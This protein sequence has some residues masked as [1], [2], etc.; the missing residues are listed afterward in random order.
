MRVELVVIDTTQIQR[1]IF[2]SNR[3]R[4]NLGASFL[5]SCAT[6]EWVAE[7]LPYD[8]DVDK[9]EDQP[10]LETGKRSAEIVY[11]GG[12]NAVILFDAD[13]E[14]RTDFMKGYSRLLLRRAPGLEVAW[15]MDTL[16]D[17]NPRAP[18]QLKDKL[19]TVMKKLPNAKQQRARPVSVLGLGITVPCQST[20][21]PAVTMSEIKGVPDAAQYPVS[22]EIYAKLKNGDSATQRLKNFLEK[23]SS[24][25]LDK[26]QLKLPYD[27]DNIGRSRGE[28]SYIAVVHAD[29]DGVGEWLVK[30]VAVDAPNDRAYI[31]QKRDAS[32]KLRVTAQKA[33]Q[34]TVAVLLDRAAREGQPR[35]THNNVAG[36]EITAVHF[37]PE[38]N[39]QNKPTGWHYLPFRPIVFGGDDVTFI[40]DGRLAL[41][42]TTIYLQ[43]FAQQA[44]YYLAEHNANLTA[45]AGVAI[46]KSHYPFA[47][48]Y[49]LAEQLI[50]SAKQYRHDL[51]KNGQQPGACIDWHF[52]LG[53]LLGDLQEIRRQHYCTEHGSLT[54]RPLTLAENP[55][56]NY[57]TWQAVEELVRV[58]QDDKSVI[59]TNDDPQWS[60]RRNKVKALR[61]T[62]RQGPNAVQQ[63][64]TAFGVH[65]APGSKELAL[66]EFVEGY[67]DFAKTGWAGSYS[68]YYDA[69]ELVDWYIPLKGER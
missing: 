31:M 32:Q 33:M 54:L 53:G 66:P 65:P 6:R 43:Q 52:A 23:D 46:V 21:L 50:G 48:A 69:I 35:I 36:E 5:V 55:H 45:S 8:I 2:G 18:L 56:H 20:G 13:T 51:T 30:T 64:I 41:S 60:T 7:A 44:A 67:P 16:A 57:R 17:W 14:A 19:E 10:P 15:A 25:D 63:F 11:L 59:R 40:C 9:L 26:Q 58:F 39:K 61:D 27:L 42:L 24:I 38:L 3:L 62:L 29:G 34:A 47:R 1:Y 22:A 12:G 4:E 28:H 68:G 49:H 37:Q